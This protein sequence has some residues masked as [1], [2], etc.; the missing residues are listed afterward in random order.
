MLLLLPM[1]RTRLVWITKHFIYI[2]FTG[3]DNR[4]CVYDSVGCA[5]SQW[6]ST[7]WWDGQCCVCDCWGSSTPSIHSSIS[8]LCVTCV[9][10]TCRLN[11]AYACV[12]VCIVVLLQRVLLDYMR[13]DIVCL[14]MRY[15]WI[16]NIVFGGI[17]TTI[18]PLLSAHDTNHVCVCDVGEYGI[19]NGEQWWTD[20]DTH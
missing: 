17:I 15:V 9:C 1:M 13:R 2:L 7:C 8:R 11:T 10:H 12:Q 18:P 16:T 4:W 20:A 6:E 14:V 5:T 3:G 19:E